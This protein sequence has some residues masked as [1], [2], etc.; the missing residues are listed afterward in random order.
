MIVDMV[1][2]YDCARYDCK[3]DCMIIAAIVLLFRPRIPGLFHRRQR[4]PRQ[5]HA[6]Q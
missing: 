2:R 5:R 1:W 4:I 6:L 3:Y